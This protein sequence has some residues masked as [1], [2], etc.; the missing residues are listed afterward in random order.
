MG[1][2]DKNTIA[3]KVTQSYTIWKYIEFEIS[4]IKKIN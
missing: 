1:F 3:V 2:I 4:K